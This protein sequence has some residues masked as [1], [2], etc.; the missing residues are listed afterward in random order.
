MRSLTGGKMDKHVA[1]LIG[2]GLVALTVFSAYRWQ[3][4]KR[5]RAVKR[6]VTDYLLTRF[7]D[8]L[9]E[10]SITCTDDRRWPVLASCHDPRTRTRHRLRFSCSGA[11][12]TFELLSE[13]Q[14]RR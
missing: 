13:E 12:S 5:V 4:R 10:L 11:R 7:G 6:W 14:E 3:Q 1:A 2:A 9:D 8:P